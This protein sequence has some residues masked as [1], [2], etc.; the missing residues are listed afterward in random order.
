MLF[1]I[2][3]NTS[4]AWPN[5]LHSLCTYHLYTIAQPYACV[6]VQLLLPSDGFAEKLFIENDPKNHQAV[7]LRQHYLEVVEDLRYLAGVV[8]KVLIP[9][10]T[11]MRADS[12]IVVFSLDDS[13]R[14]LQMLHEMRNNTIGILS[15]CC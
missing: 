10:M 13:Q 11:P 14:L 3:K 1:N 5:G 2:L 9:M 8:Q 12:G 4:E 6:F 7:W 15:I